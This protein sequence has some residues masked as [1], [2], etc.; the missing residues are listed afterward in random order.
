MSGWITAQTPVP[1][2]A[3][4]LFRRLRK[5]IVQCTSHTLNKHQTSQYHDSYYTLPS[6]LFSQHIHD[7]SLET[8]ASEGEAL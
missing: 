1:A 2:F 8:H 6:T 3:A 4:W 7:T 5:A